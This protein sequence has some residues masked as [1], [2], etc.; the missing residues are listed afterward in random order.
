MLYT[1]P[2]AMMNVEYIQ[3]QKLNIPVK[4]HKMLSSKSVIRISE[5]DYAAE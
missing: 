1:I 2:Y 5:I 4:V 3:H